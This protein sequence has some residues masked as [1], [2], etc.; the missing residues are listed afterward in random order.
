[1]KVVVLNN[2]SDKEF[3]KAINSFEVIGISKNDY[4]GTIT[5]DLYTEC[6]KVDTA[7]N[8]FFKALEGYYAFNEY[9]EGIM[10][11][12]KQGIFEED[13]I[14]QE[15]FM[16]TIEENDGCYYISITIPMEQEQTESE[17]ECINMIKVKT[18]NNYNIFADT[19]NK[20]LVVKN[21]NNS[22]EYIFNGNKNSWEN[23]ITPCSTIKNWCQKIGIDYITIVAFLTLNNFGGLVISRIINNECVVI[24][25]T[26][27]DDFIKRRGR[28]KI[29][30]TYDKSYIKINNIRFNLN[31]FMTI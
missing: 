14:K 22:N 20:T 5:A 30:Y 11:D 25:E 19:I 10:E 3:N 13:A 26:Y 15:G 7:I 16:F 6:K 18:I 21:K 29:Y 8:R 23:N 27:G 2:L 24:V 28:Y 9:K 17:E 4:N 31:E 12:I 1:M